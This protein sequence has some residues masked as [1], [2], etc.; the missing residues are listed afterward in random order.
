MSP[1]GRIRLWL[2]D[3]FLKW[4]EYLDPWPERFKP[5]VIYNEE[6]KLTTIMLGDTTT[7]W[8]PAFPNRMHEIDLGFDAETGE[9]IGVEIWYDARNRASHWT[10]KSGP[11]SNA[12]SDATPPPS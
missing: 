4:S 7:I 12:G 8:C 10:S 9:L 5:G 6:L 2:S 1:G 3:L 11:A